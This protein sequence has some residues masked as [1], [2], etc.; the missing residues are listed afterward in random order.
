MSKF[1]TYKAHETRMW[2]KDILIP[3]I[4]LIGCVAAIPENRQKAKELF[5]GAKM[6]V[7]ESKIYKTVFQK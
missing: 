5:E 6:K 3:A 2:I 1:S 7:K 4:G